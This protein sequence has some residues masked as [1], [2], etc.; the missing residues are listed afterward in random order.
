MNMAEQQEAVVQVLAAAR[1]VGASVVGIGNVAEIRQAALE[2]SYP[3]G[4]EWLPDG[5]SVLVLGLAH[6][7][8]QPEL[9]W[10]GTESGTAGNH[11]LKMICG[12]VK[13]VLSK[14]F[15]I[16]AHILGYQPG[17]MG[18]YLKDAAVL[19]GL[20]CIGDNNL[21]IN[22]QYGP[23]LRLRGMLLDVDLPSSGVSDFSPCGGCEHPC[24]KACPQSAFASGS[25]NRFNCRA[26]MRRD[27]LNRK[28]VDTRQWGWVTFVHY[29]RA[30]E[31]S[32]P[33]GRKES[34]TQGMPG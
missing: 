34:F 10:W 12:K 13:S 18:I 19:A 14:Q 2:R 22:P 3:V 25:Y 6:P 29:C 16:N 9:D 8:N 15:N 5:R 1:S 31:F 33:V 32:C 21:L 20:G 7:A 27:E 26:Q 23:R 17:T 30:C 24:W 4:Q 28:A 11:Q